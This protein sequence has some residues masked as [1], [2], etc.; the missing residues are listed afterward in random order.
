MRIAFLG[1]GGSGKTTIT[2]SFIKYLQKEGKEILA[3]D[4]DVNVHLK[5]ALEMEAPFLGNKF[6]EVANYL[7][8]DKIN[9]KIPVIGTTTPSCETKFIKPTLKDEFIKKFGTVKDNVGLIACGTYT[10]EGLGVSC[11]HSKLGSLILTYNRLLDNNDFYVVSDM[12]AGTDS[13]GTSMY[14]ISDINIFV[15]EPTKKSI[16][17][18]NDYKKII[19]ESKNNVCVIANKIES[20]ED[21]E[22][23][24]NNINKDMILGYVK[25]SNNLRSFEQ[26]NKQGLE[27]FVEEMKDINKNI[28]AKLDSY[29]KDWDNYYDTH[30]NIFIK[31]AKEWYSEYYKQDLTKYIDKDFK[32]GKVIK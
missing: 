18:L 9:N 8:E 22:F 11:Y 4:A 25:K 1:K 27:N 32:Y 26:G 16:Q 6:D 17:V 10:K 19:E 2:T 30:K 7:E 12:T 28:L 23:I 24:N 29:D 20:E 31:D 13:A 15:V 5:E 14:A 21:I 3:V